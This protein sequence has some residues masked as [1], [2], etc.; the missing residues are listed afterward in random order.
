MRLD[1]AGPA[2]CLRSAAG[3]PLPLQAADALLLAWLAIEGPTPR[4]RLAAL[5][6]P[7]S[8]TEAARNALRQ[9]LFR[10]RRQAGSDLVGGSQVLALADELT[11][12]LAGSATLLGA[13][14]TA[15]DGELADWLGRQRAQR[16]A[17][18]RRGVE[19]RIEAL[20]AEGDYAAALPLAQALIDADPHSEDAHRRLM[21]LHYLRGDK[22]AA[23]LAF[24]RCEEVLKHEVGTRP[25]QETLALLATIESAGVL[26]AA[27]PAAEAGGMQE[28]RSSAM[29]STASS[30]PSSTPSSNRQAIT[31]ADDA[32]PAGASTAAATPRR[33][34]GA[35]PAAVLRPPRLIGRDTELAALHRGL[36]AGD[37]VVLIGEAGMGKSRLLQALAAQRP[38]LLHTSGRPGDSLVPY[39]TLARALRQLL[40]RNPAAADSHLRR[41]LGA[42]LPE[43]VPEA[44]PAPL[45]AQASEPAAAA[46]RSAAAGTLP[47]SMQPLQQPV[48][49]LLGRAARGG[50]DVLAL[51]DLHFADDATLELLQSLLAAP[52]DAAG[53]RGATP[54]RCCLGLRPAAAGTRL[55]ALIEALASAGPH[56][57]I[58]LQPLT[59]T[60]VGELVD[61]LALPG[62]DGTQVAPLLHQRTGGNPLFTL[63][64]LKLAW[65]DGSIGAVGAVGS[66]AAVGTIGASGTGADFS[67]LLPRPQTLAQLIGQQLARLSAAAL[68]L[69]RVAA[70]AGVDFSIPLAE[71]LLGRNALDLADAWAE[72]EAQQVLRGDSFAHDLI[73]DAVLQGLPEV[74]NRHLHGLAAAWLEGQ[75]HAVE[76]ARIAAH[77][78]AAG[79]RARALPSLRAAAELAHRALREGE[80]IQFLLHAAEIAQ[81]AERLD[82]AFELV[83]SAIEGH[84]NT[85]RQADGLPLLDR[86]DALARSPRQ[87][88]RAAGD[89]AWYA[90]VLGDLSAAI[91]L[92]ET[93][94][95]LASALPTEDEALVAPIRQRLGTALGMA[96]R[97]AQALP[98]M[99]AAQAWIES[100]AASDDRSEFQGNL[101]VM[102]D[103]LGQPAQAQAHHLRGLASTQAQGDQAHRATLLANYALN[104]LDAGDVIAATD[105]AAQAQR[106][107][108]TFEMAGASAGFIATLQAQCA[109]AVGRYG[110]ALAWCDRAEDILAERN[111]ARLPVAQLHRAQV[112]LDLGQHA[113]AL[114]VLDG[115]ALDTARALPA[116]YAVR[117]LVLLARVKRRLR[118]DA[119]PLLAQAAALSP[120]AGWPE[121][122]LIVQTEAALALPPGDALAALAGVAEIARGLQ[123]RGAQLGA[124]LHAAAVA[125]GDEPAQAEDHARAALEL[126]NH[127]ECLHIDRAARWLYPALALAAAGQIDEAR[128]VAAAGQAWLRTTAAIHMPP[129]LADSF[130]H[131]HPV[132]ARLMTWRVTG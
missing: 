118:Q 71:S 122:R 55:H 13:L 15:D 50:I 24:D 121:L 103:N 46:T 14:Q 8:S 82:E 86:L 116:R 87:R 52:R 60:Q 66:V 131:Q 100:H 54:L 47:M 112:W 21:R 65:S 129:E 45:T 73:H 38:G 39:A 108:S 74:I 111:P 126:A 128:I 48:T 63:E 43:L 11:H 81:S 91:D 102:L 61:S 19:T 124:E 17:A 25:S 57:R 80:R 101:A 84:M 29:P 9:R 119:A 114:Q 85:I 104:R 76:P 49:D 132:N 37:V 127:A 22:A 4:D 67:A 99:Q 96:G 12:D 110:E 90:T 35:V 97:F 62:I 30:T 1:L 34:R 20:E 109:R 16:S 72:L 58:N 94:L 78:E 51:D 95:A 75:A 10:L 18:A 70:V 88:A 83:R 42:V 130:L 123:L 56:T 40:D 113:R 53:E 120:D 41:A 5:L 89:R 69:A 7:A 59:E 115:A 125:S 3:A 23:M 68:A 106:I 107:V 28:R 77:W 93:A 27:A 6:W 33:R 105:Q 31:A 2:P 92:G 32:A 98:H 79:Q 64:T 44:Q 117:W 26:D 36:A